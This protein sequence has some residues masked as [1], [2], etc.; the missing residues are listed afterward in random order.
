MNII[1]VY[2]NYLPPDPSPRAEH[3]HIVSDTKTRLPLCKDSWLAADLIYHVS[4]PG[5]PVFVLRNCFGPT[6]WLTPSHLSEFNVPEFDTK[7]PIGPCYFTI[8]VRHKF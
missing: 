2:P 4:L 5:A 8:A 1:E 6:G 3:Y 7:A